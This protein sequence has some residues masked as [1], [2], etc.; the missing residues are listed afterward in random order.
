MSKIVDNK[1]NHFD[2]NENE[3]P[4]EVLQI[5]HDNLITIRGTDKVYNYYKIII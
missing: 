4:V 2:C 1:I 5:Y 3:N